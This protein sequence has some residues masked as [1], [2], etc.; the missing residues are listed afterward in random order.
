MVAAGAVGA[1]LQADAKLSGVHHFPD[2]KRTDF[3]NADA[4]GCLTDGLA[5]DKV[6]VGDKIHRL[7]NLPGL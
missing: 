7:L 4:V 1:D 3:R 6:A 5:G 2:H